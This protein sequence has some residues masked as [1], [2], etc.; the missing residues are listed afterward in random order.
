[1]L[2]V[3]FNIFSNVKKLFFFVLGGFLSNLIANFVASLMLPTFIKP[4]GK[5]L[6][7]CSLTPPCEYAITGL[8]ILKL[9][10]DTRPKGFWFF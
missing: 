1:M 3:V 4:L 9:S 2:N 10:S 8:P 6:T 7:S 5:S